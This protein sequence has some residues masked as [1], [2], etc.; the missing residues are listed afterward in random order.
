M[1][2]SWRGPLSKT[3][4]LNRIAPFLLAPRVAREIRL[5]LFDI[6]A[7]EI[8]LPLGNDN[9]QVLRPSIQK[10]FWEKI[11]GLC[12]KEDITSLG[13]TRGMKASVMLPGVRVQ[14]GGRFIVG[15]ALLRIE[16]ALNKGTAQRVILA[17]DHSAA[18]SLAVQVADTFKMPIM[19]QSMAPV[20]HEAMAWQVY[21][22]EGLA[23]SLACFNPEIWTAN[24]IILLLDEGYAEEAA[25][26]SSGWQINLTDSSRGHAPELEGELSR[27]GIAPVLR[28][29]APLMEAC[30]EDDKKLGPWGKK[31][32]PDREKLQIWEAFLDNKRGGHYNTIKGI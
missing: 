4:V 30:L 1:D 5:D 23:L 9:W 22:R 13:I 25:R 16:E 32:M 8:R 3:Q 19:L 29:L 7:R 27:Q 12:A 28:N 17:S 14:N 18:F 24:D 15:L 21:R 6:Q 31:M 11:D 20:R 2:N 26:F 10:S